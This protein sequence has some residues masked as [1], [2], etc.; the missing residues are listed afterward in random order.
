MDDLDHLPSDVLQARV[1]GFHVNM[2]VK[3]VAV[4]IWVNLTLAGFQLY[5]KD[6]VEGVVKRKAKAWIW[7][8]L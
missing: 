6:V 8:L 1:I 3:R 4:N 7:A 5:S 2:M